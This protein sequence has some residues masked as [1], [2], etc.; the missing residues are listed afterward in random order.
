MIS[1][2][3]SQASHRTGATPY[4]QTTAQPEVGSTTPTT[5][6]D[7]P[8]QASPYEAVSPAPSAPEAPK[9]SGGINWLHAIVATLAGGGMLWLGRQGG[10]KNALKTL[11]EALPGFERRA[12]NLSP[13]EA[14]KDLGTVA[15]EQIG[16][17][18]SNFDNLVAQL[19]E[20]GLT[21]NNKGKVVSRQATVN[22][23]TAAG[24]AASQ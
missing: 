4:P 19:P 10:A 15:S 23:D 8:P 14:I 9:K 11:E 21:I 22:V 18:R 13:I 5:L 2:N 6:Q 7:S 12:E 20:H 17:V 24:E 3:Y 1:T 16:Y